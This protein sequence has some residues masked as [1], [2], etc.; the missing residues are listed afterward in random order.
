M[1][2]LASFLII[3]SQVES[4][5]P[6]QIEICA[7]GGYGQNKPLGAIELGFDAISENLALGLN[8][9]LHFY[10]DE[11][12][13]YRKSIWDE[14]TDYAHVLRYLSWRGG[15]KKRKYGVRIGQE[16]M[17]NLGGKFVVNQLNYMSLFSKPHTGVL[18]GGDTPYYSFF[19]FAND[20]VEP[21][22]FGISIYGKISGFKLGLTMFSDMKM[23]SIIAD[24]LGNIEIE[25]GGIIPYETEKFIFSGF[26][27]E[28]SY[29]SMFSTGIEFGF[30]NP[31]GIDSFGGSFYSE[32]KFE[33]KYGE[34]RGRFSLVYGGKNFLPFAVGP[35]YQIRRFQ[36]SISNSQPM[37]EIIENRNNANMGMGFELGIKIKKWLNIQAGFKNSELIK[38]VDLSLD[39]IFSNRFVLAFYGGYD[40]NNHLM[41]SLESRLM[42]VKN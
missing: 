26:H 36:F 5:N 2:F 27:G 35:F 24:N 19:A 31:N 30:M 13:S 4:N 18:V 20:F 6:T 15:D 14:P 40:L 7:G 38:L 41:F 33:G 9:P 17:L 22:S 32:G 8:L 29:K 37:Y 10:Y 34:I 3:F 42:I 12:I 23:P 11:S 1:W 28:W 25:N 21:S 39:V 16:H